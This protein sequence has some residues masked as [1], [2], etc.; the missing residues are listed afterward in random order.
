[1]P[2][3]SSLEFTHYFLHSQRVILSI[4]IA[5]FIIHLVM[6]YL[7]DFG[8]VSFSTSSDLL[9]NPIAAIYTPFSFIL[10]YEVYLLIYYLPKSFTTY[11]IKQYEIMTIIIIR[12]LF[13][14]L[15]NLTLTNDW[16]VIKDDLQFT[17]DLATSIL[18]FFLIYLFY[19]QS[20]IRYTHETFDDIQIAATQKFV[21]IK[22]ILATCLV[23]VLMVL[24]VYSFSS[25]LLQIINPNK[26]AIDSFSD[27]NNI[28][29]EQ[30]FTILIFADV[31]LLLF[32]FFLTDEF[33]KVIRNSGFIISTILIRISFSTSGLLNNVLILSAIT[34]GLLII[35]VHN[36][37]E[38][39]IDLE[40]KQMTNSNG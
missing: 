13:K 18:M 22:K 2:N 16:F 3:F 25:W 23:P 12:R 14:D 31:L 8:L 24:A 30:F 28:F 5:S 21:K 35:I 32:S 19:K 1:M 15:S 36:K 11:I 34:F 38:R 26:N 20:K 6:I 10:L 33:H 7:V 39:Q 29:F 4:A 40:K 37:F 9:N 27:I 17:Y